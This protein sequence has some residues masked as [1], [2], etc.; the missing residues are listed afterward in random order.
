M[1]ESA[2]TQ[3][4]KAVILFVISAFFLSVV[5]ALTGA[6]Q[7]VLLVL[8]GLAVMGFV[9]LLFAQFLSEEKGWLNV[10]G[11]ML[12]AYIAALCLHLCP[13]EISVTRVVW[14]LVSAVFFL[15]TAWYTY[16]V[17]DDQN[18]LRNE[19]AIETSGRMI[20][21]YDDRCINF[22]GSILVATFSVAIARFFILM[23]TCQP[24]AQWIAAGIVVLMIGFFVLADWLIG[25]TFDPMEC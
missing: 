9:V 7:D 6:S 3:I 4:R 13:G 1:I 14:L 19:K 23:A 2:W 12:S 17:L 22:F 15:T 21:L 20:F 11:Y 18:Q 8:L 24:L 5:L 10:E 16:Q 25:K